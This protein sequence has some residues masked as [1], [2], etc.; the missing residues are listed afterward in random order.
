MN[1]NVSLKNN[2]IFLKT[3][4]NK[5]N[6]CI[7]CSLLSSQSVKCKLTSSFYS[8]VDYI[9]SFLNVVKPILHRN[10]YFYSILLI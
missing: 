2:C 10:I 3:E 8:Q 6:V 1:D 5:E 9:A 4:R 7:L